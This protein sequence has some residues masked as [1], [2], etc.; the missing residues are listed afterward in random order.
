MASN[1]GIPQ[2][3]GKPDTVGYAKVIM[4]AGIMEVRVNNTNFHIW[5]LLS[6]HVTRNTSHAAR[7]IALLETGKYNGMLWHR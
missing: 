7:T 3:V 5:S 6:Q 4:Q 1:R 2:C